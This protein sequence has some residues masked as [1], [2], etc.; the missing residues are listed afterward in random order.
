MEAMKEDASLRLLGALCLHTTLSQIF[1]CSKQRDLACSRHTALLL[2]ASSTTSVCSQ[3]K[4]RTCTAKCQSVHGK[5]VRQVA[6]AVQASFAH[7]LLRPLPPP[8]RPPPAL[9]LPL[10]PP[11]RPPRPPPPFPALGLVVLP[12]FRVSIMPLC[13][14]PLSC[15]AGPEGQ[16]GFGRTTTEGAGTARP[17][18]AAELYKPARIGER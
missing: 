9:A 18:H 3:P 11:P 12:S 17:L 2:S 16:R 7:F 8:P 10:R 6:K 14:M 4:L 5:V 1:P 15:K 13:F